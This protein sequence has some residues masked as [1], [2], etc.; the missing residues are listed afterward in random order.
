MFRAPSRLHIVWHTISVVERKKT[1]NKTQ[2]VALIKEYI[3]LFHATI[4]H[5]HDLHACIV[6]NW[7]SDVQFWGDRFGTVSGIARCTRDTMCNTASH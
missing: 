2:V 5:M 3:A 6:A 1:M 4:T 7:T